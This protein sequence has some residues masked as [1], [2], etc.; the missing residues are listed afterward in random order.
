[1]AFS[2]LA[3]MYCITYTLRIVP[4]LHLLAGRTIAGTTDAPIGVTHLPTPR[5]E[6]IRF[7]LQEVKNYLSPE[8]SGEHLSIVIS[9]CLVRPCRSMYVL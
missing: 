8:L 9:G 5:E 2:K 7:I 4:Y 3:V 6:D 1:M